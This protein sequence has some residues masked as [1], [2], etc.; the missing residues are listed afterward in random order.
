M[1][2]PVKFLWEQLDGPQITAIE[3]ALFQYFKDIFDTKLDYLSTMNVDTA[4]D[5][6]LTFLG[7]LA[8]FVRPVITVPDR[9]FFYLTNEVEHNSAHGFAEI[10]DRNSNIPCSEK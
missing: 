1:I 3:N 10:N 5:S 9:E 6:H 2:L 7:I 4:N 8:N